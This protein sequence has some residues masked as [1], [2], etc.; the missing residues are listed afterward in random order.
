M[1]VETLIVGGA[2]L[3][4]LYQAVKSDVKEVRAIVDKHDERD[5]ALA[6]RVTALETTQKHTNERLEKMDGKLE[7]QSIAS[8]R[9]ASK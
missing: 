4:G 9:P 7:K 8:P 5:S 2:A 3:W 1:T 6:Q